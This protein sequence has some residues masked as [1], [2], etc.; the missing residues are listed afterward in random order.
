M[1]PQVNEI[2]RSGEGLS[3]LDD[4]TWVVW[5]TKDGKWHALGCGNI[6][7]Q[8]ADDGARQFARILTGQVQ[9]TSDL[10][11]AAVV[12]YCIHAQNCYQ[13]IKLAKRGHKLINEDN[14][15]LE[16]KE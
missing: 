7:C 3:L 11:S 10:M 5:Q 6:L 12:A 1:M 4:Y 15:L 14:R 16:V 13:A 8:L 9:G 2:A